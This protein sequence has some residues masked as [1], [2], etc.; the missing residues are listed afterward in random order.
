MLNAKYS[1]RAAL[2][3]VTAS[4]V[5]GASLVGIGAAQ[6]NEA[7]ARGFS[8]VESC[9]GLNG[10]IS[11]NPGLLKT[12]VK[13]QHAVLTGTL[14]GCSGYNG[15]QAGTGTVTAVLSGSSSLA[16]VAET[17]TITV[18]W[19]AASGLNPS[20]GT[21][22]VRRAAADQPF[23]VS[24]SVTSGAFTGAVLSTSLV[25]TTQTGTGTSKHPVVR[26]DFI[27]TLPVA[28]RVNLG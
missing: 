6:A 7:P 13:T 10:A 15:A 12:S 25:A 8:S 17:G 23:T 5:L 9:T 26:Q 20:N 24:G 1:A 19:P 11:W 22:A 18:N 4:S 28:A 3:A 16:S 2:L 27:N 21:V 14:S